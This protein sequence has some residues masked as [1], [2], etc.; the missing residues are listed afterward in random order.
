MT[1]QEILNESE[2]FIFNKDRE[3]TD[4]S[5]LG[6]RSLRRVVR[7]LPQIKVKHDMRIDASRHALASG[8]RISKN[9]KTYWET[10]SD[11]SDAPHSNV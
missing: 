3:E 6:S 1:T 10:C 7:K 9:G 5:A 4:G 11:R 2:G 8:K